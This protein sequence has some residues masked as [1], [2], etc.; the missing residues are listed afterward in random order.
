MIRRDDKMLKF[1]EWIAKHRVLILIIATY[2]FIFE[3]T[4]L[5]RQDPNK[6]Q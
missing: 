3:M 1:G 2:V 4:K 5:K 6:P